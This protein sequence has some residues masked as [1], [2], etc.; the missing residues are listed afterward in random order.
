MSRRNNFVLVGVFFAFAM[1]C[2]H[3]SAS[4]FTEN[5]VTEKVYDTIDV[6]IGYS[7]STNNCKVFTT[8]DYRTTDFVEKARK[9]QTPVHRITFWDKETGKN[10]ELIPANTLAPNG[11]L[12]RGLVDVVILCSS[13]TSNGTTMAFVPC[14]DSSVSNLE[15]DVYFRNIIFKD[16]KNGG[17]EILTLDFQEAMKKGAIPIGF[18][19]DD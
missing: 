4:A 5:P 18:S 13:D 11:E 19:T 17:K 9:N 6:F 12:T 7:P 14:T 8:S 15:N 2:I 1:L 3:L 10:I 16:E